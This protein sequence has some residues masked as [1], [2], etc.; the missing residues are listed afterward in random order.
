MS[1]KASCILERTWISS[2]A[3]CILKD[4]QVLE[5]PRISKMHAP[6][7]KTNARIRC[8]LHLQDPILIQLVSIQ[9]AF[10]STTLCSRFCV[11][12]NGKQTKQKK[13][14]QKKQ[15]CEIHSSPL[16]PPRGVSNLMME[17][18]WSWS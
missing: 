14:E 16:N 12:A 5:F 15:R 6:M 7:E 4:S 2:R 18:E 9:Y 17:E 13:T 10:L 11:K 8:F 3:L 1:P